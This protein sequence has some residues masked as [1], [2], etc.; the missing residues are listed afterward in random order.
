MLTAAETIYMSYI[1]KELIC[2]PRAEKKNWKHKCPRAEKKNWKNKY[3]RMTED[4]L[5]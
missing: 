2:R 4:E 3:K 5:E 1:W